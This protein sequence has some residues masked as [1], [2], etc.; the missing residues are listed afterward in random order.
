M[1]LFVTLQHFS[2]NSVFISDY[3]KTFNMTHIDTIDTTRS[4]CGSSADSTGKQQALYRNYFCIKP[5]QTTAF[6]FPLN[7]L[8][9]NWTHRGHC[10]FALVYF[11]HCYFV[12]FTCGK[13]NLYN[14]SIHVTI[15]QRQ[16]RAFW[17]L[18]FFIWNLPITSNRHEKPPQRIHYGQLE[19]NVN[20]PQHSVYSGRYSL[21][22]RQQ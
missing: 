10:P 4:P 7:C 17:K 13:L 1:C 22:C 15:Q 3:I 5:Y 6:L 16:F 14:P 11:V 12:V 20:I 2:F 21:F 8:L 18:I 19:I 9:R